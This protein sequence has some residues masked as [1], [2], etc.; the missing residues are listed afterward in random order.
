[1]ETRKK[2]SS[3][4]AGDSSGTR[5]QRRRMDRPAVQ[6]SLMKKT[7]RILILMLAVAPLLAS[8]ASAG[9]FRKPAGELM[10]DQYIV[11]LEDG[12]AARPG[13][14]HGRGASD[15]ATEL[16]RMYGGRV[17]KVWEHAIQG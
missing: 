1:M 17:I 2:T 14:G 12:I 3:T 15:V 5:S 8:R 11:I 13:K 16:T 9:G 7:F 4:G 10:K 6:E